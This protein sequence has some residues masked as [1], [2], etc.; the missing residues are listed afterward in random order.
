MLAGPETKSQD[1]WARDVVSRVEDDF[2]VT[3][4]SHLATSSAETLRDAIGVE[5]IGGTIT[6]S[7]NA[8]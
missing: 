8:A 5:N 7:G 6:I 4:N 1:K 3:N 2:T